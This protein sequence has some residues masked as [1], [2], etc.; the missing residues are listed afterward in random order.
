MAHILQ[1]HRERTVQRMKAQRTVLCI[2]DG[3]DLNYSSLAQCQGLGVIGTNQTSAQSRG[4]P[5]PP[6]PAAPPS[7]L[8]LGVLRAQCLAPAGKAPDDRRPGWAVP[9]EEKE[10]FR[11]IEGLRDTMDLAAL[12]PQTRILN[13]CDREADFFELFEEIRFPITD[14]EG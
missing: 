11:W 7:G 2:Q 6:P 13:V 1:P 8:P 5:L 3:S 10:T 14:V 9:I 12:M 4:L